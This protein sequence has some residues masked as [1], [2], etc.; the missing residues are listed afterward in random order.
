MAKI[1]IKATQELDEIGNGMFMDDRE[2]DMVFS[3]Y[4]GNPDVWFEIP[5]LGIK[6]CHMKTD[7]LALLGK[8]L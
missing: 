1:V 8:L 4:P 6:N 3:Y 5:G 7:E 2:F